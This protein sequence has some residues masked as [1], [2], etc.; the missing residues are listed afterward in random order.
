MERTYAGLPAEQP[1]KVRLPCGKSHNRKGKIK[2]CNY[3]EGGDVALRVE[4]RGVEFSLQLLDA[5]F[6]RGLDLAQIVARLLRVTQLQLRLAQLLPQLTQ[7]R[8]VHGRFLQNNKHTTE[9]VCVWVGEDGQC[10]VKGSS[11]LHSFSPVVSRTGS[12]STGQ[13]HCKIAK[14]YAS[15]VLRGGGL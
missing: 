1:A 13:E 11:V 4:L 9:Q 5:R 14:G 10:S 15:H 3:L 2:P 7:L 12:F 8:L 6:H